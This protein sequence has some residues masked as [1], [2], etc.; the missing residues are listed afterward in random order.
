MLQISQVVCSSHVWR[1]ISGTVQECNQWYLWF[2]GINYGYIKFFTFI[3]SGVHHQNCN[4][5][6]LHLFLVMS[7]RLYKLNFRSYLTLV[8]VILSVA[9]LLL[10]YHHPTQHLPYLAL[11]TA[12]V[13]GVPHNILHLLC[14]AKEDVHVGLKQ[15]WRLSLILTPC[16]T[17]W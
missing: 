16:L 9:L 10:T 17:G 5:F 1:I 14:V 12:L 3:H 15:M 13:L 2:R 4:L 7:T 6:S 8:L 11:T